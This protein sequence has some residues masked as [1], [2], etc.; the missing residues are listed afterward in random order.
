LIGFVLS[1]SDVIDLDPTNFDQVLKSELPFFVEFFAP[2]CGH[3]KQL[4][5][6]WEKVATNLKGVI[7][8]GKVDCSA[9]ESFCGKYG[10]KGFPTIKL[11]SKKGKVQDYQQGR[12]VRSIMD[13]ATKQL[14]NTVVTVTSKSEDKFWTKSEALP[15]ALLFST[16]SDITPLYKSMAIKYKNKIVFGQA[17]NTESDLT[18]RYGLENF[19][20]LLVF[21]K[22][23]D[24]TPQKFD[25]TISPDALDAFF[26]GIASTVQG[27]DDKEE[28][29]TEKK[30]AEPIIRR[31]PRK[32]VVLQQLEADKVDEA[33]QNN[34]CI[35]GVVDTEENNIKET[36]KSVLNGVV[37]KFKTDD[38]LIF[39]WVDRSTSQ[40]LIEKFSLPDTPSL[41]VYNARRKR[42]LVAENFEEQS[43]IKLLE[44][45]LSG[46]AVYK[47]L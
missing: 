25:G 42:Y 15:H 3:C 36:Q 35:I 4:A 30:D 21:S 41:V 24:E 14:E 8:V 1:S 16:K 27:G 11:F 45:V 31:P 29:T 43:I 19:P 13:F 6:T 44:R 20:S 18:T 12:D 39:A 22:K 9:H 28:S 17:K 5:P 32:E 37:E 10:V 40:S 38:K 46:D 47:N 33:C 2:W 34:Y 7:P 26:S 23:D